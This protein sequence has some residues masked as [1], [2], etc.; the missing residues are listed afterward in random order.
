LGA[1]DKRADRD[2]AAVAVGDVLNQGL[3]VVVELR[4]AP[5]SILEQPFG[6]VTAKVSLE[7]KPDVAPLAVATVGINVLQGFGDR[8]LVEPLLAAVVLAARRARVALFG[9][10]VLARDR[11]YAS[12]SQSSSQSPYST[13]SPP[14]PR[15]VSPVKVANLWVRTSMPSC[16]S[17]V[18]C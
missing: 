7:R 9:E 16:S 17:S 18:K 5:D 1:V 8:L 11:S 10:R 4:A 6:G 15:M 12:R 14:Q 2:A 13:T 3:G